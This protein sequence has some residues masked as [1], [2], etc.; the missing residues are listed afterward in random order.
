MSGRRTRGLTL[1][2]LLLAVLLLALLAALALP[3]YQAQLRRGM[4]PQADVGLLRAA[5]WLEQFASASGHYPTEAAALPEPLRGLPSAAYRIEYEPADAEGSGYTLFALP[6]GA[7]TADRCGAFTLDHAGRRGL[8]AAG[9][10]D[11]LQA[12]CLNH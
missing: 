7:Q 4:R 3:S 12:E 5:H 1:L 8:A 2:E 10:S 6:Q 9:A 11:E